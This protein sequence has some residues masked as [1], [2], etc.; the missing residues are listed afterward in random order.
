M[1]VFSPA[2]VNLLKVTTTPKKWGEKNWTKKWEKKKTKNKRKKKEKK[3]KKEKEGKNAEKTKKRWWCVLRLLRTIICFWWV[4]KI[5]YYTSLH[6]TSLTASVA[7]II[8]IWPALSNQVFAVENGQVCPFKIW[9]LQCASVFWSVL[10]SLFRI[11]HVEDIP[12]LLKYFVTC[13]AQCMFYC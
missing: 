10:H 12:C 11:D 4:C 3:K 7:L 6:S 2:I 5:Y 8:L 1:L 13:F 9:C